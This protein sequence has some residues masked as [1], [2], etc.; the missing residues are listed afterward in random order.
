MSKT[1][2]HALKEDELSFECDQSNE[3]S[4]YYTHEMIEDVINEKIYEVCSESS[5]YIRTYHTENALP[6]AEYI[7]YGDIYDFIRYSSCNFR[8]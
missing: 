5:S 4:I 1:N 3:S 7:G 6:F 2:K 8:E